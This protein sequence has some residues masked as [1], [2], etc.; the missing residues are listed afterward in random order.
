MRCAPRRRL[1]RLANDFGDLVVADLPRRAGTRLVEKAI[2]NSSE[3]G[4]VICDL[5]LGSGSTLI[6]AERTGRVCYGMELD[7][8]YASVVIARY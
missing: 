3:S 1:E 7:A 5:F 4:D 2:N 8:H 6:A